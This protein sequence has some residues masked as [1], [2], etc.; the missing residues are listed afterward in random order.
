MQITFIA[1]SK[2][3]EDF[4]DFPKPSE[5]YIPNFYKK[6]ESSFGKNLVFN[7]NGA[8]QNNNIKMCMPFLDS[9]TTGY[10]Q[11]TWCDIYV[12]K[13]NESDLSL[14]YS[15]PSPAIV[16]SRENKS[17]KTYDNEFYP[18]EFTWSIEWVN[19]LPKGY[20]VLITHPLN[21]LDLPFQTLSGIIDS[22]SY[23]HA[24]S[25]NLPFY[26]KKDFEGLIP[27]GTP[28]Y[29]IIPL[30]RDSWVSK[31]ENYSIENEKRFA[32]QRQVFWGFYK[33]HC[34]NKKQ[35]K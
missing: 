10:I 34:W 29:Q 28:M 19:K 14:R 1:S 23:H 18:V 22:D 26:L 12:K 35:Y 3:T 11:E 21:R 17:L 24:P 4:V 6:I 9:F 15:N 27:K 33:K 13:E 32:K 2:T 8:L 30:K 16:N 7:E 20:S 5:N 25:G 31:T